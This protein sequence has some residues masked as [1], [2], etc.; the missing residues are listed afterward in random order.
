MRII[1]DTTA[2]EYTCL[3]C[4]SILEVSNRDL[5]HDISNIEGEKLIYRDYY[6]CPCCGYSNTVKIN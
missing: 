2:K 6:V 3:K 5:F 1:R 4:N